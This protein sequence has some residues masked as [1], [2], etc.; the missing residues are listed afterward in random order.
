ME[1]FAEGQEVKGFWFPDDSNICV[2]SNGVEKITVVT[3]PGQMARVPWL[4]VWRNG[5]V[6]SKHNMAHIASVDI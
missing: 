5:K 4:A 3:E 1:R 6:D 2:G